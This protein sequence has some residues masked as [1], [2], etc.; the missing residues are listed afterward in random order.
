MLSLFWHC[1]KNK[2]CSSRIYGLNCFSSNQRWFTVIFVLNLKN[3]KWNQIMYFFLIYHKK[4]E[5]NTN[6][7][8]FLQYKQKCC[9][10]D[11]LLLCKIFVC[12]QNTEFKS[13]FV[14]L[15]EQKKFIKSITYIINFIL[16]IEKK[17]SLIEI[18]FFEPHII[19]I[20]SGVKER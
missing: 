19:V 3:E 1:L 11:V 9:F 15:W 12:S 7:V 2:Y 20:M 14:Y 5:L 4:F 17:L 8:S 13:F 16:L 18:I 10:I 6:M